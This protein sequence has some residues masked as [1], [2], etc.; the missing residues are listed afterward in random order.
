MHASR[1]APA[2]SSPVPRPA[3]SRLAGDDLRF[4]ITL[5]LGWFAAQVVLRVLV[6]DSLELDEAEQTL[7]AREL[8]LGY[9][10]QPPLYTW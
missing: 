8:A 7:A 5:M 10:T 1:N 3:A 6:S 9:G 2:V 4:P